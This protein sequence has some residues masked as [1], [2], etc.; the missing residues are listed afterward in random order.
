MT[1]LRVL[2]NSHW[3]RIE[4]QSIHGTPDCLGVIRGMFVAI[5]FK[6]GPR[7]KIT[8]LQR[9][10][11]ER[12]SKCDGVALIMTPENWAVNYQ[13]LENFAQTG[14]WQKNLDPRLNN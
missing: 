9:Y 4:Q 13:I 12:V 5:E 6:S 14:D 11:L 1:A 10:N 3:F 7:A 8:S 2:P